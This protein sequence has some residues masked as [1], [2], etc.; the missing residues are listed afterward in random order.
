MGKLAHEAQTDVLIF[1]ELLGVC[2]AGIFRAEQ[3]S[4]I[5]RY[6]LYRSYAVRVAQVL[7]YEK[8]GELNW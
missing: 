3:G 6:A 7:E 5:G 1:T 4:F 8:R 2:G